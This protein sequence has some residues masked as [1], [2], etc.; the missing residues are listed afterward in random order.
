MTD[1]QVKAMR[2]IFN[3]YIAKGYSRYRAVELTSKDVKLTMS[4]TGKLLR[5]G[6]RSRKADPE[7]L[8]LFSK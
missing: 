6:C 5:E 4:Q 1:A 2:A 3:D 8:Q 7:Q